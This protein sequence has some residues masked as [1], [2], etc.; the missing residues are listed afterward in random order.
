MGDLHA[1]RIVCAGRARM[2]STGSPG[3][4]SLEWGTDIYF[5]ML[6]ESCVTYRKT[7]LF[8]GGVGSPERVGVGVCAVEWVGRGAQNGR[9]FQR[10]SFTV[11]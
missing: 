8:M 4:R 7:G 10:T 11:L 6:L 5:E 9:P 3:Q 2:S 1:D